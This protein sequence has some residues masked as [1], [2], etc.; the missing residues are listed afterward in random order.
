MQCRERKK[1]CKC[2]ISFFFLMR[3]GAVGIKADYLT[4]DPGLWAECPPWGVFLRD[5][6]PYLREFWRKAQ[7]TRTARSTSMTA[8]WTRPFRQPVRAQ[9][10]SVPGGVFSC[11]RER[12][13][14]KINFHQISNILSQRPLI[15]WSK[16]IQSAL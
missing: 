2:H 8:V 9:N 4:W 7:K 13:M 10:H 6:S 16:I 11:E 3:C 1:M 5:P 15:K 14:L 12:G